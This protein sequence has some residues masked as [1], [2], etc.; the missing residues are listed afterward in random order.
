MGGM[1]RPSRMA[2]GF[3]TH[4]ELD[5]IAIS[6]GPRQPDRDHLLTRQLVVNQQLTRQEQSTAP[7]RKSIRRGDLRPFAAAI[8]NRRRGYRCV[9]HQL[10]YS[11][12]IRALIK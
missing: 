12:Q 8:V 9:T 10:R 7:R 3:T 2:G 6:F 5:L 1:G 11:D 4:H